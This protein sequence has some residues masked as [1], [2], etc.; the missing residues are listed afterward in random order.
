LLGG[1]RAARRGARAAR[2]RAPRGAPRLRRPG[3]RGAARAERRARPAAGPR[4]GAPER[5]G[6]AARRGGGRCAPRSPRRPLAAL[7]GGA[8]PLEQLLPEL[9]PLAAVEALEHAPD[10]RRERDRVERLRHVADGP[11]RVRPLAV[12]LLGA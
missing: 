9:L 5:V 12:A 8:R 3:A 4:H 6:R 10:R 1:G 2:A 7:A 11:E